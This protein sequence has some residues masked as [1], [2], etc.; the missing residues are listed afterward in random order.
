MSSFW[1]FCLSQFETELSSQQFNTWIRPLRVELGEDGA[2]ALRLLAPN[3]FI[4]KWVRE[5]YLGRI[6]DMAQSF[7]GKSVA[8]ELGIGAAV[9]AAPAASTRPNGNEPRPA[10]AR[11]TARVTDETPARAAPERA[12]AERPKSQR[13]AT[14]YEKSRL[15]AGFTFDNLIV[16]KANDLARAAATRVATDP[17]GAQYNPLFIYGGA[18]LGKTHLIHA[19]GN[20]IVANDPDKVVRYVH[21]E[22][23][24]SDVV[25]AYQQKSFDVFKRYY[26][27]LDVLLLDDVQFFNNKNRTQEEFFY[28]FNALIEA[29]KQIVISCDTYPKDISGLEDRLITR[30]DW[31]LTVQIEPPEIEM[32]VAILKKKAESEGVLLDDEVAFFIA[33]HL[34]SNVRELEGA[35]KKVLAYASFHC[36]PIG[37]ELA[38]EALKDMIGAFNRQI[39]VENIQKTVADYYKIKVSDLFSKKRTR[40]IARPRQVA[41]WLAKDLTAQSYPSIGDA[42]GG[43]DH[44]TVLHAV[45]TIESLRAKDSELNHD[46]HVLQQVLKG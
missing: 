4:Q 25:R 27:S 24:Y 41:M 20:Q 2:A 16:G 11:E 23:Y 7:F 6:E 17:G 9:A 45:R 19:I 34:R 36:R 12:A 13:A 29:R 14:A 42:F 26:R 31:G 40:V 44:T 43:R 33:K 8:V 37:L 5:R 28:V 15:I 10:P 35:L 22:D 1:N 39:T 21:A 32:R 3:G 30:F 18:G 46:L 38:K